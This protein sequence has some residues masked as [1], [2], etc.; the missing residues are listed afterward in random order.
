MITNDPGRSRTGDRITN[1]APAR[2]QGFS[3]NHGR[4][5]IEPNGQTG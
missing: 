3:L 1:S 2:D 5:R 4:D